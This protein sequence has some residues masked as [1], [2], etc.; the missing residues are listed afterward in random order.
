M[1]TVQGWWDTLFYSTMALIIVAAIMSIIVIG[2]S[3][4]DA[5][6][7]SIHRMQVWQQTIACVGQTRDVAMPEVVWVDSIPGGFKG[8]ADPV[9]GKVYLSKGYWQDDK[10]LQHEFTHILVGHAGHPIIPFYMCGGLDVY[11][12]NITE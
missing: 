6:Q 2:T 9:M 3:V 4:H 5:R 12:Y 1:R 7:R 10:I 11:G 8:Y